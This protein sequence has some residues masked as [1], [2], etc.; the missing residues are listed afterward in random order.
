MIIIFMHEFY[1]QCGEDRII[2]ELVDFNNGNILDIGAN[3]GKLLSNSLHFIERGWGGTLIEASPVAFAKLT[4]L[5]KQNTKIQCLQSC[6]DTKKHTVTFYH[7]KKHISENDT[8]LLS[9]I[10]ETIF[11]DSHSKNHLFELMTLETDTYEQIKPLLK[12]KTYDVVSIDIE[13]K[14]Y[15]I[16]QQIDL[17][18][19]QCKFLI[20]EYNGNSYIK[21]QILDYCSKFE[22]NKII[23]DNI[24]NVIL[25]K[26]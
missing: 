14:D 22:L 25:T 2:S 3:D 20:I 23:F 9:T 13:G 6:L 8:D 11:K 17:N 12:Y 5:H 1:S 18:E 21:Q 26:S 10:D 19:I 4:D 16:L 7:N 24:V 15:E